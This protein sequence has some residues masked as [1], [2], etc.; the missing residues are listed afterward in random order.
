MLDKTYLVNRLARPPSSAHPFVKLSTKTNAT[1]P[2]VT[3][4]HTTFIF[5]EEPQKVCKGI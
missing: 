4:R 5:Q 1:K 3:D 2:R